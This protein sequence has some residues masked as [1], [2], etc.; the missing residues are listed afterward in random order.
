MSQRRDAD[1]ASTS[2][3][4]PRSPATATATAKLDLDALDIEVLKRRVSEKWNTYPKDVLPVWVAEMDFPLAEPIHRVLA[5]AAEL[6]DV[7]YPI[8]MRDTGL[9]ETFAE[10]MKARF[11]WEIDPRRVEVL[12]EVVQ[13][14]YVCLEVFSEAGDGVV[15]Q[16]PIYPPFLSSVRNMK[17]RL[18]ENQL[19]AGD[20]RWEID[21]DALEQ[22]ID[23]TTRILLFCN[24]HNPSGRTFERDELERLAEIVCRRDLIVVSDEIHGD[25][26]FDG[27]RHIPFA[28]LSPEVASRTVT[29]TSA[30]K[31]FNIPGLRCAMAHFGSIEL[32]RQFNKVPRAIR[33]GIG[34]MGIYATIAAWRDSQ[35]WL[36][37]VVPY[38]AANRD[39]V[40]DFLA[41][42]LPEIR[43]HPAEAT[44]L[45]WLDCSALAIEG[46]PAA[47]FMQ[48][49]KVLLSDGRAF[50][51]DFR[52]FARLNFATSRAILSE[53]LE[54][55]E[56]AVTRAAGD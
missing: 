35:G 45:A 44:Y 3:S 48:H 28:S 50:G 40:G 56:K 41:T 49:E 9:V 47:H 4:T 24:P 25:L 7:G 46:S 20:T 2:A 52:Q 16:T 42:R 21:F 37:Q 18:I 19:V 14:M 12:S 51:G 15:V 36:D 31:A 13:G 29:L 17:R 55:V 43:I 8:E 11:A 22:Q 34:L 33:G 27:R 1:R 32:Q 30:T 54:R 38:L 53:A 5:Q 39:Y 10:R 23:D 6:H 26:V